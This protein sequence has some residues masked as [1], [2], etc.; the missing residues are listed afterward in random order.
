MSPGDRSIQDLAD[1][2]AAGE[3]VAVG[4]AGQLDVQVGIAVDDVVAAAA[5]DEVAAAAAEHDVAVG[6]CHW[7][8]REKVRKAKDQID[9]DE[10][11]EGIDA[12]DVLFL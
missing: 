3:D 4:I 2:L 8:L 10:L 12:R 6:E 11:V 1:D 7:T 5:L 9:V